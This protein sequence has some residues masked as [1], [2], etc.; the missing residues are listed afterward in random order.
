MRELNFPTLLRFMQSVWT[1]LQSKK[2]AE[3]FNK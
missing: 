1:Y 2:L 3:Y